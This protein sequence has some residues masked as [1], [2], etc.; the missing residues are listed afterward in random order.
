M[1]SLTIALVVAHPDDGEIFAGGTVARWVREGHR[2]F[3]LAATSGDLGTMNPHASRVDVGAMRAAELGRAMEV[4]GA[5][6]PIL[7]G[8]PDGGVREHSDTL[9]E[10]LVF[11]FRKLGVDRVV[12][13][14]PWKQY[15]VHPDHIA[16]GRMASEAAAFACFPL[17][18]PEHLGLG[19]TAVGPTSLWYMMPT[20]HRPNTVVDVASTFETKV[21]SFLCHSSQVEMLAA[22]FVAGADPKNLSPE[23]ASALREGARRYLETMARSAAKF[24]PGVELGEAFYA[25]DVSPGHFG[26]FQEMF[27]ESVERVGTVEGAVAVVR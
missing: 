2:V 20:Q 13:S 25:L 23:Q 22:W 15:E 18:Y 6:P 4:V 1:K 7:L 16:V 12:T 9:K 21:E 27:D 11:W 19:L 10:R 14:D 26:N 5:N 17:L 3:T 8:F 24:A